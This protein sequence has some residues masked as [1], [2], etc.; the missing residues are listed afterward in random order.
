MWKVVWNRQCHV[1]PSAISCLCHC[2]PL[3]FVDAGA[4]K[5]ENVS[6]D[7]VLF[8]RM[9][10]E[11]SREVKSFSER[12]YSSFNQVSTPKNHA[13]LPVKCGRHPCVCYRTIYQIGTKEPVLRISNA[14][15]FGIH[16]E[17]RSCIRNCMESTCYHD[18]GFAGV[19]KFHCATGVTLPSK[20]TFRLSPQLF[21]SHG[22]NVLPW[23]LDPIIQ[24]R[25]HHLAVSICGPSDHVL[26]SMSKKWVWFVE[27]PVSYWPPTKIAWLSF[28]LTKQ[29]PHKGSGSSGPM[30][31]PASGVIN[32]VVRRTWLALDQNF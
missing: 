4:G 16:E 9:S 29:C 30:T 23:D 10:V 7:R 18:Q 19:L 2:D 14:E 26:V 15:H 5:A 21:N 8:K 28:I 6:Q 12:K 27:C 17:M 31:L 3:A 25:H 20:E 24:A 22:T 13:H 32:S 1:A 11:P